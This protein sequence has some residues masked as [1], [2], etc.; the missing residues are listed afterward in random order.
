M[1][2]SQTSTKPKITYTAVI[3]ILCTTIAFLAWD[4]YFSTSGMLE[5]NFDYAEYY[6]ASGFTTAAKVKSDIVG[7]P[8]LHVYLSDDK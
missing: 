2:I 7:L 4:M 8:M 5:D 3:L 6:S 1:K